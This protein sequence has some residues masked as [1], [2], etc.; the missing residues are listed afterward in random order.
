MLRANMEGLT[1]YSFGKC[2][3]R[4]VHLPNTLRHN[5]DLGKLIPNPTQRSRYGFDTPAY[6]PLDHKPQLLHLGLVRLWLLRRVNS[7]DL[8]NISIRRLRLPL[9]P[10]QNLV[11][12]P[13]L[14]DPFHVL[15]ECPA[16]LDALPVGYG[17]LGCI[18]VFC[19]ENLVARGR[20]VF[21]PGDCYRIAWSC[22]FDG[23]AFVVGH[24]ADTC[25]GCTRNEGG[26]RFE[27]TTL[28]EDS[29]DGTV[30]A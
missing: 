27:R 12:P 16:L 17:A 5:L 14:V 20:Y 18:F 21:P 10:L 9:L 1:I 13:L 4:L 30:Y 15:R 26:A 3:V 24:L 2:D 29:G 6:I 11:H 8:R 28:D 25:P 19:L 7:R 22:D 23:A